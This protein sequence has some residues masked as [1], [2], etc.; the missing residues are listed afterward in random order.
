MIA[1]DKNHAGHFGVWQHALLVRAQKWGEIMT[2]K[3]ASLTSSDASTAMTKSSKT[4]PKSTKGPSRKAVGR[5]QAYREI[6]AA[7]PTFIGPDE[8]IPQVNGYGTP[9]YAAVGSFAGV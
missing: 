1:Q 5:E 7:P 9:T 4:K 2:T 3:R 8:F 6:F